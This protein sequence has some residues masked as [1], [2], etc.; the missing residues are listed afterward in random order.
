M[1]RFRV[2]FRD[3]VHSIGVSEPGVISTTVTVVTRARGSELPE[4]GCELTAGGL[5]SSNYHA[6][7]C[8]RYSLH[9]GDRIGI[10]V[11]SEGPFDPPDFEEPI[12]LRDLGPAV[13]KAPDSIEEELRDTVE[14]LGWTLIEEAPPSGAPKPLS[15]SVPFVSTLPCPEINPSSTNGMERLRIRVRGETHTIGVPGPG[16]LSVILTA[17]VRH[18]PDAEPEHECTLDLGGLWADNDTANWPKYE[19]GPGDKVEIEVLA[20]GAFDPPVQT[21]AWAQISEERTE[22]QRA[23]AR[24]TAWD[25][26]WTLIENDPN[27]LSLSN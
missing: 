27:P 4:G 23:W 21:R 14:E 5:D 6:F 16:V 2:S 18:D 1:E 19:L 20:E 17:V 8:F 13:K 10:E 15:L 26:G 24:K 12:R 25:L 7:E 22:S 3:E 9:A 11:L